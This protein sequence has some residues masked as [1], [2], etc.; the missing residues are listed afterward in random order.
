MDIMKIATQMIAAQVGKKVKQELVEAAMGQ[1]LGKSKST[2]GVDLGSLI[3]GM[4]KGGLADIADSWLGDGKNANISQKQVKDVFGSDKIKD[5][6]SAL[7]ANQNQV[8]AGL[9]DALPQMV[10]KSSQGGNLLDAVGGVSGLAK[11]AGMFLKK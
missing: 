7:G 8:L 9:K 11:L 3:S 4:Q 10:D 1:L 2:G 6:A 5:L